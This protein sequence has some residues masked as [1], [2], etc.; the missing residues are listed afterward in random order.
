MIEIIAVSIA[1]LGLLGGILKVWNDTTVKIKEIDVKIINMENKF[2]E[3]KEERIALYQM[4]E[5]N[6]DKIWLKLDAIDTKLDERFEDLTKI[7]VEHERNV[8]NYKKEK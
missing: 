7:K 5:K 8:C 6:I 2:I 4:F 3:I 1:F